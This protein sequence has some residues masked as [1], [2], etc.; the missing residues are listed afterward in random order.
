MGFPKFF[1]LFIQQTFTEGLLRPI[2]RANKM[3]IA[4]VLVE[5]PFK[6]ERRL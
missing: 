4:P 3:D 2:G 5:L 1:C 6:S